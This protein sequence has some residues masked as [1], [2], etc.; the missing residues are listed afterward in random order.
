MPTTDH[1]RYS[2]P[3]TAREFWEQRV[4]QQPEASF[5]VYREHTFSYR[6]LD[7]A[8]NRIAHG[9][10]AVGVGTGDRVALLLPSDLRLL[11]VELALFKLGAVMVPMIYGLTPP[12]IA[13]VLG[14]SEPSAVITDADGYAAISRADELASLPALPWYVFDATSDQLENHQVEDAATLV[15]HSS[16]RLPTSTTGPDDPMAIMYTSGSTGKPKGVVQPNRGFAAAGFAITDRLRASA[17]DGFF[18]CLPMYHAAATHMLLAP[19]IAAGGRFALVPTFSRDR[20]WQ[21]VRDTGSTITLLMPAQLAIL[22]TAEPTP[23]DRRHP[24]RI[25]V[26]HIQP[27]DFIDRFGV[28]ITVAWAM[29]ETSGVGL[30][31]H[32]DDL[33]ASKC[34]GVPMAGAA[35]KIVDAQGN[36]LSPGIPGELCFQHPGTL[37]EYYR[38]PANTRATK[39]GDWVHSGDLCAMDSNGAVYFHGRIKNVIKRAG[40]NIA[41]EEIEFCIAEHPQVLGCVT[42]AVPDPIY[43]E[44]VHAVTAVEPGCGMTEMDIVRWC[45][46]RLASWKIPRY[47]TLVE[48]QLPRLSNGKIDR[49]RVKRE[50]HPERAWDGGSRTKSRSAR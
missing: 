49:I 2:R 36:E 46:P 48:G 42:A 14:H 5:L 41:G 26:S 38:D 43:T 4:D 15:S 11:Q 7:E 32:P 28:S 24:L 20:F 10:H 44:E 19:A 8:A 40:E 31:C 47:I 9:L 6:D 1:P 18:C 33:V 16:T 17:M 12:E 3:L 30:M 35:A 21:Q 23:D 50:N 27:R 25:I 39:H 45:E 34:V 37:I 22:M 13:Y 29:T